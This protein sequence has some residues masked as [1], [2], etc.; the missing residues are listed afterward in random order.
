[1]SNDKENAQPE[2]AK[3]E[4]EEETNI[5]STDT[6][7]LEGD[8]VIEGNMFDAAQ[9]ANRLASVAIWVSVV[10]VVISVVRLLEGLT[11]HHRL[12]RPHKTRSNL[13]RK[14]FL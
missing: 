10:A 5:L 14:E 6:P 1:M 4:W 12:R 11:C 3:D 13:R 2:I 8:T 9:E 7:V